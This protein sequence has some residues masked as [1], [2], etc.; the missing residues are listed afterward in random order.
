LETG[1]CAEH[2]NTNHVCSQS[3]YVCV[4]HVNSLSAFSVCSSVF[5]I[6]C[7]HNTRYLGPFFLVLS[8]YSSAPSCVTLNHPRHCLRPGALT[9]YL[10]D[11]G[12]WMDFLVVSVVLLPIHYFLALVVRSGGPKKAVGREDPAMNAC[13]TTTPVTRFGLGFSSNY[14]RL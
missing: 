10:T 2:T 7:L 1:L 4:P 6:G 9:H 3:C 5:V 11:F 13:M 12:K 8:L 14:S